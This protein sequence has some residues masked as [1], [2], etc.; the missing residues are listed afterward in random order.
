MFPP[1]VIL[2]VVCVIA[3]SAAAAGSTSPH[4]SCPSL[5]LMKVKVI[6]LQT[7]NDTV[8]NGR[9]VASNVGW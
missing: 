6:V 5:L 8:K 4:L 1:N 2:V 3:A 9:I 7:A